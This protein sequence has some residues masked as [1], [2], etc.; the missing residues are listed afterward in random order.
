[1]AIELL[2]IEIVLYFSPSFYIAFEYLPFNLCLDERGIEFCYLIRDK[3]VQEW[4]EVNVWERE[5]HKS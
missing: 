1:M 2:K 3:M 5:K 4:E